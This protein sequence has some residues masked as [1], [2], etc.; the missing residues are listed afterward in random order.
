M[1]SLNEDELKQLMST[2]AYQNS[3]HPEYEKTQDMV[4]QGWENLYPDDDR[5]E[6]PEKKLSQDNRSKC[7]RLFSFNT[8]K[9]SAVS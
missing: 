6:H 9:L 5:N 3:L 2:E 7:S 1:R 8:K 4:R